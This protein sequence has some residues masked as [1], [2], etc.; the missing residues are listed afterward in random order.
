MPNYM[1]ICA[2]IVRSNPQVASSPMAQKFL[3][4]LESGDEAA[5]IELA[6][7]L[8]SSN[9]STPQ[10]ALTNIQNKLFGR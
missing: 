4:I 2:K 7:N 10:N 5:G 8:C 3:Q 1:D 6:Q 9:N